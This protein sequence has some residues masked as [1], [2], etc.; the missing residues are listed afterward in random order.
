MKLLPDSVLSELGYLFLSKFYYFKLI[1]DKKVDAYLYVLNG[2]YVGFVSLTN[3]PFSFMDEG[4]KKYFI[5]IILLLILSVILK[6]RRIKTFFKIQREFA[7]YRPWMD[8][9]QQKY[10]D[11]IGQFLSF[12][13]DITSGVLEYYRKNIDSIEE[14]NIPNAMI[15]LV[16]DHFKLNKKKCCFLMT[17]KTNIKAIKLYKKHEGQTAYSNEQNES[18]IMKFDL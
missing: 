2:E 14:I 7:K 17:M 16:K 6:P 10:K 9:M 1:E 18:I 8:D 3:E 12:G 4:K 15:K 13:V 5:R 11:Q